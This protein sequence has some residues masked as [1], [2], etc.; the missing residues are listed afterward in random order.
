MPSHI[1]LIIRSK[2]N[3]P[4]IVLGKFKEQTSKLLTKQIAENA[5]ENIKE[6]LQ[7]MMKWA[8]SKSSNVTNSQFWQHHNKPIEL[9]TPE[10]TVQRVY[11]IHNNPVV[12]GFVIEPSDWKYSSAID[13][14]GGK[15][16]LEIDYV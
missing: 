6:W 2:D 13:Y 15:G 10:V 14:A 16:L 7:W 12:S 8:A 4:E 5:E 9:W 11:Y 1:H 3:K